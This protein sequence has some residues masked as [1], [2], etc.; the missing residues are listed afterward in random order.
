MHLVSKQVF[1]FMTNVFTAFS[2]QRTFVIFYLLNSDIAGGVAHNCSQLRLLC[3]HRHIGVSAKEVLLESRWC[4]R[5]CSEYGAAA[6]SGCLPFQTGWQSVL[7][8]NP[9]SEPELP[10]GR[11]VRMI[12]FLPGNW[13]YA[14]QK[15]LRKMFRME[16]RNERRSRR[17]GFLNLSGSSG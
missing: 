12:C 15:Q 1:T 3:I 10:D 17:N 16:L 9:P 13:K 4:P 8:Q 7:R 11:W 2:C 14:F 5:S 6:V